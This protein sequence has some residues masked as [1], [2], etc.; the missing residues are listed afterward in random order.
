MEQENYKW[1]RKDKWLYIFSMIPFLAMLVGT[2]YLLFNYSIYISI[3]WIFLYLVVNV[4]Q[5][6]CC[7]GCPYRGKYCPAF[8]GV[9][10]GN[11]LS[12]FLYKNREFDPKFYENNA[13]AGEITLVLFLIFPF[14]WIF[15]SG[16]YF[17]LIY[18]ALI[19]F[20]IL[21][22]MPNQCNKCS[23]NTICPGGKAYQSY[24]KIIKI[25]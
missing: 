22:F 17:I 12:S 23:Y 11:L 1:I 18:I 10:F 21:L 20:H 6:G 25:K 19:I 2:F 8:C 14:Y 7:V 9:Y 15:L 3:I 13:S 16:W 24:C 4:F 5:A